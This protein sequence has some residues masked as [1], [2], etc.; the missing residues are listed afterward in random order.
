M[1]DG[2]TDSWAW[3]F[4]LCAV[5]TAAS[6][7]ACVRADTAECRGPE[8]GV[9]F[10][11][12]PLGGPFFKGKQGQW[13]QHLSFL[14]EGTQFNSFQRLFYYGDHFHGRISASDIG[15]N[16]GG[17][18]KGSGRGEMEFPPFIFW[19]AHNLALMNV[20]HASEGGRVLMA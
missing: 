11:L 16:K 20:P 19:Q 15:G 9:I 2:V 14:W 17:R 8:L 18:V 7:C 5:Y 3:Q 6:W 1:A 13:I 4:R 12:S 10:S